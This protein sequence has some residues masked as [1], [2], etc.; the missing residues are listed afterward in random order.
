M[1]VINS[2]SLS[3]SGSTHTVGQALPDEP[4]SPQRRGMSNSNRTRGEQ[5]RQVQLDLHS[6]RHAD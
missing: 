4:E 3:Y 2:K 5:I 6:L 1:I